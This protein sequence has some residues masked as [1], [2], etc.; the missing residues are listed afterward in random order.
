M[1]PKNKKKEKE[2]KDPQK[3][4]VRL[5]VRVINIIQELGN[6]AFINKDYQEA[7]DFYSKAIEIDS[8]EPAFYTNSKDADVI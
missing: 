7:L 3:L 4:K 5:K 2:T 1:P 8:N 6:K